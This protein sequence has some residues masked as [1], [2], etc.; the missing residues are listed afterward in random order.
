GNMVGPTSR[1]T[2]W[3]WGLL[4]LA[5]FILNAS[6]TFHNVWP[7]PVIT[8]RGELSVELALCLVAMAIARRVWGPASSATLS[9]LAAIWV[10]LALGRYAAV[11]A[12]ALYGREVN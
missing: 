1:A 6:L 10:I 12:P 4:V 3:R 8:W 11:T 2:A 7:T 5:L 9:W